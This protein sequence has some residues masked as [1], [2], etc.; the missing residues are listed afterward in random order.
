LSFKATA[1]VYAPFIWAARVTT[2]SPQPLKVRLERITKGELEK[3]RRGFSWIVLAT[4]GAKAGL[5]LGLVDQ[6][7]LSERFPT[8]RAAEYLL[9]PGSW[10]WWQLTLLVDAALTFILLFFADAALARHEGGRPWREQTVLDVTSAI[11]F[12]RVV[13]SLLT[14]GYFFRLALRVAFPGVAWP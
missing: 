3:V 8:A 12:T 9:V 7:A 11:S 5:A 1:I 14:I 2:Q 13:L 4:L 10:P 6:K